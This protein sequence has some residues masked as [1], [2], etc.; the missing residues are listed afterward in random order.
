MIFITVG[1]SSYQFNRILE[2]VDELCNEG[3]IEGNDIFAQTGVCEYK[4]MNYRYKSVVSYE[5]HQQYLK[6]ADYIITHAGTGSIIGALKNGKKVIALPRLE[7]NKEHVDDHQVE[8][9]NAFNK[10]GYILTANNKE[11]LIKCINEI[12]GFKG[13]K[14]ISNS[15]NINNIITKFIENL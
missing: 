7:K 11:E 5:E 13:E 9:V 6:I 10:K 14:F 4:P 3:I 15:K 12:D 1:T 8:I 2:I